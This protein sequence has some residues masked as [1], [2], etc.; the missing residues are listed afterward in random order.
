ME[1]LQPKKGNPLEFCC[2]LYILIILCLPNISNKLYH[3]K[4]GDQLSAKHKKR[5]GESCVGEHCVSSWSSYGLKQGI[6][7]NFVMFISILLISC[8]P[9]VSNKTYNETGEN[10][11]SAEYTGGMVSITLCQL[12]DQIHP[13]TVNPLEFL[14]SIFY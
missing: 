7:W 14:F 8:L 1:Q 3:G 11:L 10:Q 9:N 2:S 6:P 12:M 4:G 5:T 13:K